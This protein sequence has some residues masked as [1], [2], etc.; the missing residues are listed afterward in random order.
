[1]IPALIDTGAA[2]S[3]I[4]DYLARSLDLPVIDHGTVSGIA[5]ATP[6]NFYLALVYV[7]DLD[8]TIVGPFAGVH[9]AAGGQ[10][11]RVLLGRTFL[12]GMVFQYDGKTGN[13]RLKSVTPPGPRLNIPRTTKKRNKP[14]NA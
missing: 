5:G 10:V 2:I 4:D 3:C 14:N 12:S 13:L 11:H 7:P 1:L 8:D 9:L 6:V